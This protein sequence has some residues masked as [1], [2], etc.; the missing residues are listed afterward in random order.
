M[1]SPKAV[2]TQ[3]L[4]DKSIRHSEQ[5]DHVLDV[6]LK[7]ERHPTMADLYGLVRKKYPNIG[8]ATVYRAMKVICDAGLAREVNFGK[9]GSRFEHEYGHEH[10]DHLICMKCGEF[11][12][13]IGPE[14]EKLQKRLTRKHGFLQK[15]HRME[16]YGIC[17]KCGNKIKENKKNLIN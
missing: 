16:I 12:E 3:Y 14:I 8:Y 11:I 2:F 4:K 10:H 1:K 6:F 17:K 5:I 15:H 13:V 7:T 9:A